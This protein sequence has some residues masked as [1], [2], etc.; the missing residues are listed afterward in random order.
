MRNRVVITGVGLLTPL[1]NSLS[2]FWQ[3]LLEGKSGIRLRPGSSESFSVGSVEFDAERHFDRLQ[4]NS[5][6]R[7]SQ[8][9]LVAAKSA[10]TDAELATDVPLG[11]GAGVFFGTGM[12]GAATIEHTYSRFFGSPGAVLRGLPI[13][14]AMAHAPGSQIALRYGVQGECQTYSTACSSSSVAVGEA[15]RRIRDGYL[16]CAIAGGA[17]CMLLPGVLSSW[18]AMRVLCK[19]P[20]G[21]PGTGCRP[22]SRD[23]TG[24]AIGEGAGVLVLESLDSAERR[25]MQPLG[26]IVGYGVSNDA[27]HI[28]KPSPEGQARA[29]RNA[30]ADA[31]L[32][33]QCIGHINAHGTATATGDEAETL[34]IKSVF[35][36]QAS[37]IPISAT[38][39]SHG[40][41]MGATGAVEFAATLLALRHQVVPP[42]AFWR[43]RDPM[44]DLDYV[45]KRGRSVEQLEYAL[46]NSFA[47]GGNNAALIAKRWS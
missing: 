7:V 29:M 14:A 15:F 23:R 18:K 5:L 30:L 39:S 19:D 28:T 4:L 20:V 12:G 37:R 47:F 41:L 21:A 6:D 34:S 22:F 25:G 10:L 44:C 13:P 3:N 9:A 42:T 32:E 27:T 35:G 2:A 43:E 26:E 45:P 38:K 46:S 8:F 24:F 17:E 33:S 1:G 36:A 31:K 40:H 11:I 16:E